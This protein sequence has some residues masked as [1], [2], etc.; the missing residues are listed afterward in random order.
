VA[1][2]S[3]VASNEDATSKQQEPDKTFTIMP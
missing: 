3:E 1:V 2:K